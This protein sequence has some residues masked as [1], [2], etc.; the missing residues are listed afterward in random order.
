MRLAQHSRVVQAMYYGSGMLRC[1]EAIDHPI[2]TLYSFFGFVNHPDS[3]LTE[4]LS[5]LLFITFYPEPSITVTLTENKHFRRRKF[6]RIT[7]Y[8]LFGFVI[9]Y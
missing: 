7:C 1:K 3:D 6:T 9:M 4:F 8:K 5:V 2:L